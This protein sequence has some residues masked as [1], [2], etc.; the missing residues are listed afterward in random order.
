MCGIAGVL[1]LDGAPRREDVASMAELQRHRGP[2]DAG[3]MLDEGAGVGLAHSRLSIL[4]LSSAG[5]QPMMLDGRYSISYNGEVYNYLELRP[6]LTARG[7]TFRSG[8]DTEVVLAAYAEWGERCLERFNGMWALAIWD[9]RE[10]TLFCARDRFGVKPFYYWWDGRH[11]VFASQPTAIATYLRRAG[12]ARVSQDD[13]VV[14][15]YLL[16]VRLDDGEETFLKGI[17]RLQPG[18]WL[19]L[20]DGRL[21]VRRYYRLDPERTVEPA[22]DGAVWERFRELFIDAVRLRLRSDVPVG[23]CLSGGLDS[24]S[25][26]CVASGLLGDQGGGE[27][28]K[29]FS[30]CYPDHPRYDERPY[31]EEVVR[32]AGADPHYV[33]PSGER[34]FSEIED[35][36]RV[37]D[38]PV[39]S[40]S[41]YAQYC[42]YRL[43]GEAGMKVMLDGQGADETLTGYHGAYATRFL[44]LARGLSFGPLLREVRL[45]RGLHGYPALATWMTLARGL[46]RGVVPR[47]VQRRVHSSRA[48]RPHPF[49]PVRPASRISWEE[50]ASEWARRGALPE[51]L[52]R[53]TTGSSLQSLLRYEDRNSMAFS[54]EARVPFLDY[55]LV[56]YAFSLPG[57]YMVRDGL[58]KVLLREAMT[59]VLPERIRGRVDKVGFATPEGQW[60][61]TAGRA[62]I[63]DLFASR[64]FHER[65]Y[66]D[67]PRLAAAF[68]DFCADGKDL[69][70]STRPEFWQTVNVFWRALN[71]EV[72]LRE[73]VEAP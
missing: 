46:A 59:G 56:E 44:D 57:R 62:Y 1:S 47:A 58:T 65:G 21:E 15:D 6:E 19:R 27:G 61:R 36:V 63:A 51:Y 70:L 55:R 10:R 18:H 35:F 13:D 26:V 71:T 49:F 68:Q 30:A 2:D 42:V 50:P 17:R 60:F 34:F 45:Y 5:H 40:T 66:F 24:S 39:G 33:Y 38:E 54:V 20:R 3:V 23:S 31:I 28:Q 29:T 53:L 73:C 69:P 37:Q 8:T 9:A 11:F 4:D 41:L 32:R 72:W 52:F 12:I 16:G 64:S 25:I 7:R 14:A 22:E 48:A 43:A 67:G